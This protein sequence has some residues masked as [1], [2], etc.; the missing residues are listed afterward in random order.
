MSTYENILS[1]RVEPPSTFSKVT[2]PVDTWLR[3][4]DVAAIIYCG[5]RFPCQQSW[6]GVTNIDVS[7]RYCVVVIRE[8]RGAREDPG[9]QT[10]RC[11]TID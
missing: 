3:I 6:V 9:T 10:W 1:S 7:R 2:G 5:R 11:I 4:G 8:R